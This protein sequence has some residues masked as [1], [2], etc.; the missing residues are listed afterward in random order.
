MLRILLF[1]QLQLFLDNAPCKFA[2]R[3]KTSPLLACL[4][5]RRAQPVAR[6]TLAYT[7]WPDETE[8]NARANL[9]RHLHHLLRAL[10][11]ADPDRPWWMG[12]AEALQWNP[13]ADYW[14][15]VAEFERLSDDDTT[16]PQAVALYT[17]D[18][19]TNLYDDWLFY[20]RERLRDRFFA[21][22]TRLIELTSARDDFA[23]ALDHAQ[24]LLRHDPFREDTLRRLLRLRCDMADRA[25]ALAEYD[26]FV[27]RLRA[28]LDVDPMPETIALYESIV[29]GA[30]ATLAEPRSTSAPTTALPFVGRETALDQLRAWWSRAARSH[31]SVIFLGGEAGIGKTRLVTE[32]RRETEQQGARTLSGG[33]TFAEPVPYQP[34]VEALRG[35]LPLLATSNI[36][37]LRL[38]AMTTILPEL[39]QRRPDLPALPPLDP[40]RDR[41]R[42]F[43]AVA[44]C[45]S[46][47]ARS[48]PVLLI[49]ED[50]HWA[51]A[52][53][54]G[55]LADLAQRLPTAAICV[56]LTYREEETPR[57]HPLR[58]LRRRLAKDNLAL[59][60]TLSRLAPEAVS[61]LVTHLTG[62]SA[63]ALA[64]R[65]Y[66]DSEGNPLFLSEL[67]RD[68]LESGHITIKRGGW[69]IALPDQ[70][71]LPGGVRSTIGA[72]LVRLSDEARTLAE[73]ACVIGPAFDVELVREAGGWDEARVLD[74]L[75][76][77]QDRQLVREAGG[78]G[79]ADFAFTHHL[80]QATLYDDLSPAIRQRRHQRV[81]RV[82][83]ELYPQRVDELSGEL[84]RHFD[85][86]G[87][88]ETA[89]AYYTRSARRALA[90]Y[91]D[92]EAL[93]A[94]DR[95]LALTQTDRA[96]FDLWLLREDI[97]RR[98][99]NRPA[100]QRDLHELDRLAESS[101]ELDRVGESLRRQIA[102]HSLLGE[103]AQQAQ[104]ID[105]L[106]AIAPESSC[107]QAE[108]WRAEA[109][110]LV[111][112][113]QYDDAQ[114]AVERALPL[115]QAECDTRGQVAGLCLAAEIATHQGRLS[116]TQRWLSQARELAE[117]T[118]DYALLIQTLRGVAAAIF[119][120]QDFPASEAAARQLLEVAR[121]I[122]DREGQADAQ[123]RL[124]AVAAR[125]KRLAE[126]RDHNAAAM[127]LYTQVGKLQGQAATH[128]N[129]TVLDSE[130]GRYLDA[131][132]HLRAAQA[133]FE[134]L[135]DLRGQTI[136]A[137]NLSR[138]LYFTGDATAALKWAQHSLDLTR[139]LQSKP[140]EAAALG[141]LGVAERELGQL[142]RAVE[143]LEASIELRRE[144]GGQVIDRCLDMA[145]LIGAYLKADRL[146]DA[147]RLTHEMLA[148]F[149]HEA[150]HFSQPQRVLFAA[151]QTYRALGDAAHAADL[152]AQACAIVQQ[153]IDALPDAASQ[154]LARLIPYNREILEACE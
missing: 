84:A 97:H 47:L 136:S 38:S 76:E 41:T 153:Q 63:P 91:A 18:L 53:T 96:R 118:Q 133:L 21:D 109:A 31:G 55:L 139:A 56:V 3:P 104:L 112:L 102:R 68:A 105:R 110:L 24:R 122:G 120:K 126:A 48:R 103:R 69:Q 25:T 40:E 107:W 29:R 81:G 108:G 117:A 75:H 54:I 89:A 36:A 123:L 22:L 19:L 134:R 132:D 70:Q 121:T 86:G 10:P 50:L 129:L 151:A 2:A 17:G 93:Q 85:L 147:E 42:L 125:L 72:R 143:H 94:I 46:A 137:V 14:L 45:L 79:H 138:L 33:T 95:A 87:D 7:L 82:M 106:K 15:D 128:M 130:L 80:I 27:R 16:L 83:L 135:N 101:G 61:A 131:I 100:Q 5:L 11:P 44:H 20:E 73:I 6:E 12:D 78:R 35:A 59:H 43:E 52:A 113:G 67:L 140:L 116:E 150:E 4:L 30:P 66:L 115:Y 74:A 88:P 8:S 26:H 141:N 23:A 149:A 114:Q 57:T 99:G 65:L 49:L 152:L 58:E 148:I 71:A 144:L 98:R 90:V 146:T 145:D 142:D 124:G 60:L 39:R 92:D 64:Q 13:A 1:N 9:R 119:V 111:Q 154:Q 77:L 32:L 37:P 62:V 28:E 51:G 127:S 34:V